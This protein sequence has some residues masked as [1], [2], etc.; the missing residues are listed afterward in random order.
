MMTL[1]KEYQNAVETLKR[2]NTKQSKIEKDSDTK[3]RKITSEYWNKTQTLEHARDKELDI[4][5]TSKKDQITALKTEEEQYIEVTKQVQTILKLMSISKN[6][7]IQNGHP[8]V[9]YY[10]DHDANG[11]YV[12]HKIKLPIPP[13]KTLVE[14][15]YCTINLYVVP[16]GKPKNKYSLF[17]CGYQIFGEELLTGHSFGYVSRINETH[18]NIRKVIKDAE[19]EQALIDYANNPKNMIKIMELLPLEQLKTLG[20]LYEQALIYNRDPDW[21]I[22]YLED[23]KYY[24]EN[25]YSRGTETPMYME[26]LKELKRIRSSL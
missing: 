25:H 7:E 8:E 1:I 13:L 18:Y 24:Y 19:T 5:E 2:L 17:I 6:H 21:Q 15:K 9:S 4:I 12:N 23:Q 11:N 20:E 3:A 22:L 26:V 16:N 14:D 10:S